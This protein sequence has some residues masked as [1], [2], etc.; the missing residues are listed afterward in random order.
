[1]AYLADDG[2]LIF[3]KN[4]T[5]EERQASIIDFCLRERKLRDQWEN[6]LKLHGTS[7]R[8]YTSGEIRSNLG[9]RLRETRN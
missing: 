1:M 6:V 4:F 5:V 7:Y 9:R 2:T 3:K 8:V